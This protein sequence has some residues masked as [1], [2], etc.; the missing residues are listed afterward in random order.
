MKK[1]LLSFAIAAITAG[2]A[3]AQQ[4][5][6]KQV[7]APQAQAKAGPVI[8]FEEAEYNF[9]DITQ[10]DVVEHTFKF[11]NTGTQPLVIERVDVTCGCTTP[12]WTKEPIMPGKTGTVTA[13]FNSAGKLGQQK[14][15]ITVHSNAAEPTSVYIVTNIKEKQ[16]SSAKN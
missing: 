8:T 14:K 11:K 12:A 10:G 7:T 9:G 13:K 16:T 6:K 5:P 3:V 4:Q 15:P 2:G 1:I